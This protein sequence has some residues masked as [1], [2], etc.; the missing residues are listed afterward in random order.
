[1]MLSAFAA[2]A[3]T[4]KVNVG[5]VTYAIPASQA[6]DMFFEGSTGLTIGNKTY[7]LSEV[8][9]ICVDDS[10]IDDNTVTVNYEGL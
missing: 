9:S 3:Q 8:T 7:S 4:M 6:G 10:A 1:M 5:N 2:T